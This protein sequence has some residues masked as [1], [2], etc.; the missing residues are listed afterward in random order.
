M[1]D[2]AT[3][4]IK[5]PEFRPVDVLMAHGKVDASTYKGTEFAS[6][7]E[8]AEPLLKIRA[9]GATGRDILGKIKEHNQQGHFNAI[10]AR[11]L[12]AR[13]GAGKADVAEDGK[14]KPPASG[15]A[16]ELYEYAKKRID[17][18]TSFLQ[19]SDIYLES[20]RLGKTP[21]DVIGDRRAKGERG[22]S[23]DQFKKDREKALDSIVALEGVNELFPDLHKLDPESRR[24][25]I[26]S[27]LVA[28]PV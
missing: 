11:N 18:A 17:T 26:E 16:K 24:Q 4:E 23:P 15:E 14:L 6:A 5:T 19:Y 3:P 20:Q 1:S 10:D 13:F 12:Q 9:E 7:R 25:L 2:T 8:K 22:I 28:D 21:D 27:T